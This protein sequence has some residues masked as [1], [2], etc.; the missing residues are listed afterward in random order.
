[1]DNG[2]P[3]YLLHYLITQ[4]GS[5]HYLDG[6]NRSRL[7]WNGRPENDRTLIFL[8]PGKYLGL[9]GV[10]KQPLGLYVPTSFYAQAREWNPNYGD[11]RGT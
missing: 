10:E 3:L 8:S 6:Y 2:E 7:A 1:M 11:R 4:G 9:D 5:I